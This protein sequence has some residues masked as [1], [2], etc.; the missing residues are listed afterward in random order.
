MRRGRT[1]LERLVTYGVLSA[2]AGVSL[3]PIAWGVVTSLKGAG[4]VIAYPPRWLPSPPTLEH[5]R[6]IF[7]GSNM[8][9]YFLNSLWVSALTI[10]LTLVVGAHGGYAAARAAF[11]G[12]NSVLFVILATM[13]IPGIAVLVP[14]YMLAARLDLLDTYTVLILVYS[15]WQVPTVLWFMRGFF[16]VIPP[17]LEEAA[18]VDGCSRLQA[19]YRVVL[20]VTQPG[21][22]AS[23]VIVFVYVW[24]EFIIAL[25][26]SSTDAMRLVPVGLYFYISQFGVEWGK[27]MAAVTVAI[28]PVIGLFVVLQRRFIQGLTSGAIKG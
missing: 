16:E 7:G 10:A 6:D 12:K 20:P 14:L 11:R 25:T 13:M 5:Y 17:E 24:N 18:L 8:G 27:L 2:A 23:A 4:E 21:L 1:V 15:A 22:A 26:M 3:F 28:V 9:R 19:L